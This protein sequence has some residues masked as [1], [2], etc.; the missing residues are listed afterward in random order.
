MAGGATVSRI[1]RNA[2]RDANE[3]DIIQV[4]EAQ[5]FSVARINGAG[6]PDLVVGKGPTFCRLVEIKQP[7]G[8]FKPKQ[9]TFRDSWRGPA[10]VTL[11]SVEDALKFMV[12]AMEGGQ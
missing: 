10:I 6:V 2:K 9:I 1:P 8:T 4:L 11:R 5:G 7:K 3:P 12:L